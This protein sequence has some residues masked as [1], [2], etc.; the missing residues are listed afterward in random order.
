MATDLSMT[1]LP[2][3]RLVAYL[4][5]QYKAN[6]DCWVSGPP[7]VGK[8]QIA[9]QMAEHLNVPIIVHPPAASME[10]PDVSGLFWPDAKKGSMTRLP[11]T[12]LWPTD[13]KWEGIILLD[14]LGQAE[15]DMQK[16]YMQTICSRRIGSQKIPKGVRFIATGNRRSDRAGVK[17]QLTPLLNRFGHVELVVSVEDWQAWAVEAGIHPAVRAFLN[18]RSSMLHNFDPE[19][20]KRSF[21]TPRTW[22]KVS[23]GLSFC[24]DVAA[25]AASWVGDEA[26][27]QFVAFWEIH[28]KLP[29]VD[30]LLA[31]PMTAQLPD[32]K[33]GGGPQLYYA[34]AEECVER[35]RANNKIADPF[36]QLASR[37]PRAYEILTVKNGKRVFPG[38]TH[39]KIG[40]DWLRKNRDILM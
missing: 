38:V 4:E 31:N 34:L 21:P 12:D 29:D 20:D 32:V 10:P 40:Q 23:K 7:G 9:E 13:E 16:C 17:A 39:S 11:N 19:A 35:L 6:L 28:E 37:F 5:D 30:E 1:K 33:G 18:F 27:V 22:E 25:H 3:S 2:P 8:T 14:E 36:M 24:R 26:A 15:P